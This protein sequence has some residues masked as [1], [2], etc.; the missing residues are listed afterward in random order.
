M[1]TVSAV[2]KGSGQENEIVIKNDRN[3][4]SE[5]DIERLIR[6]AEENAEEDKKAREVVE[7]K[8]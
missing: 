8:N 3:R 6:E 4:L 2:E 7:L 5:E 1:L